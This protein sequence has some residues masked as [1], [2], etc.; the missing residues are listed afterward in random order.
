MDAIPVLIFWSLAFYCLARG[1]KAL[2]LLF[3]G[4]IPFGSFAAIPPGAI[5]GLTLVPSIVVTIII[6]LRSLLNPS[7]LNFVLKCLKP[8]GF[9]L[10]SLFWLTAVITTIFMP[11]I[12]AGQ[13]DV[14]VMRGV[15]TQAQPL[16]PSTQNF[17][18]LAI[19]SVGFASAFAFARILRNPELR[20]FSLKAMCLSGLILIATGTLDFGSDYLPLDPL[21]SPFRTATYALLTDLEILGAKRVV[22]LMPEASAF[23]ARCLGMATVLYFYRDAYETKIFQSKFVPLLVCGLLLFVYLSTSTTAY[24]GAVLLAFVAVS[25]WL[26]RFTTLPSSDP[27]RRDLLREFAVLLTG[28]TFIIA[29]FLTKPETLDPMVAMFDRMVLQKTESQ[30]FDER[31]FWTF[32][33]LQAW[34]DSYLLGVGVGGTRA[35]NS[36]VAVFS[37]VGLV[38]GLLYYANTVQ[39]LFFRQSHASD[40]LGTEVIRGYRWSFLPTF[41]LGL[42]SG[43]TVDL[44]PMTGFLFGMHLAIANSK[45]YDHRV[46]YSYGNAGRLPLNKAQSR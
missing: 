40:K 30:S 35:S 24:V 5:G 8:R 3:F 38:G 39:H 16:Q 25:R 12:F 46:N 37:N 33:S 36:V 11:R 19:L 6:I 18:Q 1:Y 2:L 15:L 41:T 28:S 42:L 17:S 32:T 43:V 29:A 4:S 7:G 9:L 13:V 23:G 45:S 27:K 44:S 10:L 20:A 26:L 34:F 22:G 14:I 21:L 31:N